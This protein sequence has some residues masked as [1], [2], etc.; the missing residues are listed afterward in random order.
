MIGNKETKPVLREIPV[1]LIDEPPEDL[2]FFRDEAFAELMKQ[3][4]EL[5]GQ[6]IPIEVRPL[7]NGRYQIIDGVTRFRELVSLGERRVLCVVRDVDD[8]DA[9][10]IGLKLNI[11]R[12]THDF[13]G[14]AKAFKLLHDR[15]KMRYVDI[16]RRF[17][18]SKSWITKIMA[19]NDLPLEYQEMLARG[20]LS[21]EE[22]Y[23]LAR[24]LRYERV[25]KHVDGRKSTAS[26]DV[27]GK[28]YAP[29]EVSLLSVCY[30]CRHAY[31]QLRLEREKR[32]DRHRRKA[33]AMRGQTRL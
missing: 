30:R 19:L 32:L 26:C 24:G 10:V 4:L 8:L 11:R 31:A 16:A 33:E 18:M 7:N 13:M 25:A 15:F 5:E 29:T 6:I 12:K 28:D 21:V 14:L 17:N 22:G 9:V 23:A 2:R 27:C 1:D 3:D 20:D